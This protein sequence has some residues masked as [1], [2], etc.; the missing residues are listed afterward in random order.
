MKIW[1]FKG[2]FPMKKITSYIFILLALFFIFSCSEG[3]IDDDYNYDYNYDY[4]GNESDETIKYYTLTLYSNDGNNNNYQYSLEKNKI[5]NIPKEL[6][7][8]SGYTLS[9][10]STSRNGN[11]VYSNDTNIKLEKV[12]ERFL[13]ESGN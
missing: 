13:M 11:I 10:W 12:Y 5:Y 3:N 8:R 2:D 7:K 1:N 4:D 6:F 9:G